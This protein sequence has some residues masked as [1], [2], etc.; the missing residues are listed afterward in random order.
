MEMGGRVQEARGT[1]HGSVSSAQTCE[2]SRLLT[3]EGQVSLAHAGFTVLYCAGS[4]QLSGYRTHTPQQ[5]ACVA[6][7]RFKSLLFLQSSN[8]PCLWFALANAC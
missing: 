3:A 2:A 7:C 1:G 6:A 5:L 8:V 4:S